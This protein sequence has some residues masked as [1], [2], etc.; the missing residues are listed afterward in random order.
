MPSP[1]PCDGPVVGS[2]VGVEV[3]VADSD[4]DIPES[5][6]VVDVVML[7]TV[8]PEPVVGGRVLDSVPVVDDESASVA[9]S[10][11]ISV[12]AH[13][14]F[15][16]KERSGAQETRH[17]TSGRRVSMVVAMMAPTCPGLQVLGVRSVGSGV[18]PRE[19]VSF[20]SRGP[21]MTPVLLLTLLT[22]LNSLSEMGLLAIG[23]LDTS[24][25]GADTP[26]QESRTPDVVLGS[27]DERAST[28]AGHYANNRPL[29]A[30]LGFEGL[31]KDYPEEFRF[32]FNAA[33]SRHA[34]GHHA[35]AVAY[36]MEYL[37]RGKPR[38]E[39]K[40]DAEAQL[41]EARSGVVP[42]QATV[43]VAP[44]GPG[45]VTLVA[46]HIAR[47]SGDVRPELLFPAPL[48]GLRA[49][50]TLEL[51]PGT[52]IIRAQ[53]EGYVTVDQR[54]QV[55]KDSPGVA[56]LR[57]ELT[58]ADVPVQPPG[59]GAVPVALARR[60]KL[61]FAIGGGVVA[62]VGI[63]VL[64]YGQSRIGSLRNKTCSDTYECM[65]SLGGGITAR[66]LGVMAVGGG[67]GLLTGGVTWAIKDPVK[68]RTAWIAE[69]A[70]GGASLLGGFI[71]LFFVPDLYY[72]D[73]QRVNDGELTWDDH[74]ARN[75]HSVGH[76]FSNLFF[77]AGAGLVV[78]G[79]SGLVVQ[80]KYRIK[81]I[82]MSGLAGPGLSGL[83][84]SGRF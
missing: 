23:G 50:R 5:V 27:K 33:A 24:Q 69:T 76:A 20:G 45:T 78:S 30:A 21:C 60:M 48:V 34:A 64:A 13:S 47:D 25:Q 22:P 66:G 10:P 40:F 16:P 26:A 44:G 19:R 73:T 55:T 53:G 79:V 58:Q 49:D 41:R 70:V 52:W 51:D 61:G 3:E 83:T 54:V 11:G 28:A 59:S 4:A 31:W 43:S 12:V 1:Q 15:R 14:H 75:R 71:A 65:L 18:R 84:V 77:G 57:L 35:H 74:Y 9:E 68:R 72:K 62:A 17:M 29:E 80:R 42:V 63:G 32:L 46:Q 38:G 39:A 6:S 2:V 82:Q 37:E 67:L 36:T 81:N 7:D 8:T 56:T